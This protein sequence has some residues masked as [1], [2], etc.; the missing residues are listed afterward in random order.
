MGILGMSSLRR[1]KLCR[2]VVYTILTLPVKKDDRKAWTF[3]VAKKTLIVSRNRDGSAYRL[4][5][6]LSYRKNEYYASCS[7]KG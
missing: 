7:A 1:S 4:I 5:L 6:M 3:Y 2:H